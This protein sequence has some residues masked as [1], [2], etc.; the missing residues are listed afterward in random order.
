MQPCPTHLLEKRVFSQQSPQPPSHESHPQWATTCLITPRHEPDDE[1]T[2]PPT[3]TDHLGVAPGDPTDTVP[4]DTNPNDSGR[5]VSSSPRG[6]HQPGDGSENGDSSYTDEVPEQE[7][8]NK[9]T[10]QPSGPLSTRAHSTGITITSELPKRQSSPTDTQ[11]A[12]SEQ[13]Y[14]K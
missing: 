2:T 13:S 1:N 9:G 6:S 5:D 7:P 3:T 4:S 14:F 8:P 12:K 11:P 10:P